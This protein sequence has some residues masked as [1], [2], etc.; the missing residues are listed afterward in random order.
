MGKRLRRGRL[1]M[2]AYFIR[3][4]LESD[5]Y[6]ISGFIILTQS[7][8]DGYTKFFEEAKT[9]E[10]TYCTNDEFY[11][12]KKELLS[13]LKNAK[14]ISDEEVLTITK[15]LNDVSFDLF[16]GIIDQYKDNL[17]D[18]DDDNDEDDDDESDSTSYQ[19]R[20]EPEPTV[21]LKENNKVIVYGK[22]DPT[23]RTHVARFIAHIL[24][25]L[26]EL[27]PE[28]PYCK[29]NQQMFD[30]LIKNRSGML[31][32]VNQLHGNSWIKAKITPNISVIIDN[33][34]KY[35]AFTVGGF[36]IEKDR[37]ITV[38]LTKDI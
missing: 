15:Y 13:K 18:E 20:P 28:L 36:D 8:I 29:V 4:D 17:I 9:E 26:S 37:E 2:S 16:D 23:E 12:S 11:F 22:G 32:P 3:T 21:E 25:K 31:Y 14:V 24:S 10:F 1:N 33:D 38:E 34:L 7:Q 5:D 30:Y 19:K 6:T 35:G 27:K